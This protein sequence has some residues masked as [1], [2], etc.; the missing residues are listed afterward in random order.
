MEVSAK[1]PGRVK[2]A[3][4]HT[5]EGEVPAFQLVTCERSSGAEAGERRSKERQRKR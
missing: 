5:I 1:K 3:Q 4:H 2:P